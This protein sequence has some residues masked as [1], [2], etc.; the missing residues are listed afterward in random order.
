MQLLYNWHSEYIGTSGQETKKNSNLV[1]AR[2]LHDVICQS[3]L[4]GNEF[5]SP[6]IPSVLIYTL[7]YFI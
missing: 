3:Y 4:D 2:I 6:L 7:L 5:D 1:F